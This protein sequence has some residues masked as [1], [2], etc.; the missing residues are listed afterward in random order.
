M[1]QPGP[2]C[3]HDKADQVGPDH[4]AALHLEDPVRRNAP[5]TGCI[6][7]HQSPEAHV[8]NED[9][10][11]QPQ[12]EVRNAQLPGNPKGG[13]QLIGRPGFEE[14]IGRSA[15]PE[16]GIRRQD[17]AE[18]DPIRSKAGLQL[19]GIR[20]SHGDDQAVFGSAD[21]ISR[22]T[23]AGLSLDQDTSHPFISRKSIQ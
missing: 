19:V 15:Y 23:A 12:H 22:N 1:L 7:D 6:A 2:A 18:V 9:V 14:D 4:G 16:G 3:V 5:A 21:P 13:G 17:L 8:A 20:C 10:G 11:A